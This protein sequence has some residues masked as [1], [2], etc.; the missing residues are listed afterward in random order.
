[1]NVTRPIAFLDRDGVLIESNISD[2]VS[3]RAHGTVEFS[4]GA[5][6]AC[7][8]LKHLGY[9]LVMVTNP[10]DIARGEIDRRTI[11]IDD[12]HIAEYLGLDFVSACRHDDSDRCSCGKP[13]P[14]L[15]VQAASILGLQLDRRSVMIG[16]RWRDVEAGAA[17]G[18][19]T[20]LVDHGYGENLK[21]P[22]D[23]TAP[24]FLSAVDWIGNRLRNGRTDAPNHPTYHDIRRRR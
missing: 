10:P 1:V 9:A 22:P 18:V 6:Y 2:G 19:T 7:E 24:T 16:G 5:S 21:T 20:I 23:H 12:Q 13:L 15:L 8:Q 3:G 11:E 4:D 14:G 17:A